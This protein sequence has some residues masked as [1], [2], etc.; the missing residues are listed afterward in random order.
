[1]DSNDAAIAI[2]ERPRLILLIVGHGAAATVESCQLVVQRSPWGRSRSVLVVCSRL[3]CMHRRSGCVHI[4]QGAH[5][6]RIAALTQTLAPGSLRAMD[7]PKLG[8]VWCGCLANIRYDP[9][10]VREP[11]YT[12][13]N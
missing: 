11:I 4:T 2:T 12:S 1:M 8:R 7:C 3:H 9:W 5:P 6:K 10:E 13:N